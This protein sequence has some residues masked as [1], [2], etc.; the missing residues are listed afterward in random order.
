MPAVPVLESREVITLHAAL[1]F[2]EVRQRGSH[3]RFWH[4]NG[5][6]CGRDLSPIL[7]SR[8][9]RDVGLTVREFVEYHRW[10][11]ARCRKASEAADGPHSALDLHSRGRS[12]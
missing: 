11:G 9:A 2:R 5:S 1:S 7:L 12:N 10:A 3:K 8:I 4:A 6:A